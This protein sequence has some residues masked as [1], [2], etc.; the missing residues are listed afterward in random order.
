MLPEARRGLAAGH[1]HRWRAGVGYSSV[2]PGALLSSCACARDESTQR[3]VDLRD[4][5]ARGRDPRSESQRLSV[6]SGSRRPP[7]RCPARR[8]AAISSMTSSTA[9]PAG[10]PIRRNGRCRQTERRSR[11]RWGSTDPSSGGSTAT[12]GTTCSSTVSPTSC[13]ALRRTATTTSA[14][15]SAETGGAASA[16]PGKPASNSTASPGGLAG[17]VIVQRLPWP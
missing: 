6:A 13:C 3:H 4:R 10:H 14:A 9:R 15:W 2:V 11:T 5:R 8:P 12:V 17:V 16:L 1:V 7:R